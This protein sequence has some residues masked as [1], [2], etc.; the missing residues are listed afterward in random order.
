MMSDL[1]EFLFRFGGMAIVEFAL[2]FLRL[3]GKCRN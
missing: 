2:H 1:K 3:V